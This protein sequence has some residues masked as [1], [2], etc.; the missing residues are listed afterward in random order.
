M[1]NMKWILIGGAVLVA[2][3][4]AAA[5][6]TRSLGSFGTSDVMATV[7]VLVGVA[8]YGVFGYLAAKEARNVASGVVVGAG[9]AFVDA[10]VGIGVVAA[11]DGHF[12][13]IV[14]GVA[15]VQVAIGALAGLFAGRAAVRRSNRMVMAPEAGRTDPQTP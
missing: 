15:I 4:A 2:F 9:V 1:A 8:L 10:T 6:I 14:I 11:M 5:A 7:I 3:D 13:S 12:T